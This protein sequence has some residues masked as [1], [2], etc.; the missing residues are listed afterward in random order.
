MARESKHSEV[1]IASRE[2]VERFA[3]EALR[4]LGLSP[5]ELARQAATGRFSSDRARR[6]WMA[7]HTVASPPA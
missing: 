4:S 5:E 2:D 7:I 3:A 6:V 1:E